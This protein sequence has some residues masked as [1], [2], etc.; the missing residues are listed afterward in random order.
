MG[1]VA[2]R[3]SSVETS[4]SSQPPATRSTPAWLA[5]AR[6]LQRQ[7]LSWPMLVALLV[8]LGAEAGL[9]LA[10]LP[11]PPREDL[12]SGDPFQGWSM[13][14]GRRHELGLLSN[15]NTLG[16]RGA[17]ITIPKPA[18]VKRLLA[19]GDSS[20]YG[21]GVPDDAVFT[22]VLQR[23]LGPGFEGLNGGVGGYSS[24]QSLRFLRRNIAQL[25]PDVLLI[26]NLWSDN[27]FDSFV[28]NELLKAAAIEP[29]RSTYALYKTFSK[30]ALFRM[31][32]RVI[33]G[34]KPITYRR[35]GVSPGHGTRLGLRRVELNDYAKNLDELVRLGLEHGAH[36]LFIVL[37][38]RDEMMDAAGLQPVWEPY[39]AAM[40]DTAARYGAPMLELAPIYRATGQGAP[41]LFWDSMHPTVL[42]HQLLGEAL[43]RL[44]RE[45]GWPDTPLMS[46]PVARTEPLPHYDD[47]FLG[48]Q[49][50][51]NAPARP[52]A[53]GSPGPAQPI[54]SGANS[55]GPQYA[56]APSQ[57]TWIE[58]TLEG[59]WPQVGRVQIDLLGEGGGVVMAG[60]LDT[61][62]RFNIPAPI[63]AYSGVQVVF[64][65][66]GDGPN[67][68]DQ[69]RRIDAPFEIR[70][71]DK[72][73]LKV[74]LEASTIQWV[75]K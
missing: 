39:R 8:L 4:N 18:G 71:G 26:G 9:R 16:M 47:P 34:E 21:F 15:I 3:S 54:P 50:V 68:G 70:A 75:D 59:S 5:W 42:G 12:L 7:L 19:L 38:N 52:G 17:E 10:G 61:S 44:L 48:Q 49:G 67:M 1:E 58:G 33:L 23:S 51:V 28:D 53:L 57:Q 64:D 73:L 20:I 40:R 41:A 2:D 60:A 55:G 14:P 37:T 69:A 13:P 32:E 63:G 30:S 45:R 25:E 72:R 74:T 27:T 62:R 36:A 46:H 29:P 66:K 65:Q 24:V 43:A 11:R 56:G 35:I 6:Q 31:L 22:Q